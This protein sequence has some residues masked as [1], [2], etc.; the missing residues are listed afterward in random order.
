[1]RNICFARAVKDLPAEGLKI[2][3]LEKRVV[4]LMCEEYFS[5]VVAIF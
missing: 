4:G 2:R 5:G 3:I 1:M